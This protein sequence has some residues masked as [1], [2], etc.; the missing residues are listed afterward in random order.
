MKNCLWLSLT[1]A[2]VVGFAANQVF[3]RGGGGRGGAR[4]GGGG[5]RSFSGPSRGAADGRQ[6]GGDREVGQRSGN[7]QNKS[8]QGQANAGSKA[9]PF[10]PSWYANHPRAWQYSHPHADAWAVAGFGAAAAWLG[11]NDGTVYTSDTDGDDDATDD[12]ATSDDDQ[13]NDD[14]TTTT[15][16]DEK[17]LSLGVFSLS[18]QNQQDATAMVQLAVGKDG[19]LRGSYYDVLTDQD[20][21]IQGAVDKKSQR[22]FW[23][24]GPNGP[25]RFETELSQ[26]TQAKGQVTLRFNDGQTKSWALAR[27]ENANAAAK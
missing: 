3:A 12:S 9:Q 7:V 14:G 11:L 13:A 17:F 23:T 10:T 6:V 5:A 21:T 15:S 2:V 1:F 27:Y 4:P 19:M 25:V 18:P 26:L 22:I 20:Q 16:T 24:V 8:S